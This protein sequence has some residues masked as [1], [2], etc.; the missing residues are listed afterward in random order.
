MAFGD[1]LVGE[2]DFVTADDTLGFAGILPP[3][4]RLYPV[5]SHIA[6]KLHALTL[7]RARPNSRVRDLPDIAL[8]AT[9]G[10]IEARRLRQAIEKTFAFRRTHPVPA[11]V[12]APP[13]FWEAPYATMAA[14]DELP[15]AMRPELSE[16]VS[17]FL[18]PLLRST[19]EGR[20]EPAEWK[21]R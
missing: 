18:D 4:L 11:V 20:W 10:P 12:P 8:L 15:W 9:T 3:A 1:P 17:S 19:E 7:P 21:W 14:T 16:A 13:A 6:E 2:P 5:V